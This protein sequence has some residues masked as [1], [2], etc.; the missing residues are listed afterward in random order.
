MDCSPLGSSVHELGIGDCYSLIDYQYWNCTPP[1]PIQFLSQPGKDES[2]CANSTLIHKGGW[3][4]TVEVASRGRYTTLWLIV[5]FTKIRITKLSPNSW[6]AMIAHFIRMVSV[7]IPDSH[8]TSLLGAKYCPESQCTCPRPQLVT[9]L[10]SGPSHWRVDHWPGSHFTSETSSS[11]I[12]P[13]TVLRLTDF[14]GGAEDKNLP[15]KAEGVGSIP[16]AGRFSCR[17]ATSPR[18]TTTESKCCNYWGPC[19]QSLCSAIR[20]VTAMRSLH[21]ATRESLH[22]ATKIQHSQK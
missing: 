10:K 20:E 17:G 18:I 7:L 4:K 19:T 2:K 16:G 13:T 8:S 11:I 22:K 14:P 12:S 1:S 9:W 21:T 15:A 6:I 5:W 3:R